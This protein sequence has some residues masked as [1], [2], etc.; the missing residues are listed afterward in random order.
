M[1]EHLKRGKLAKLAGCNIETIRYYENIGLLPIIGRTESGHRLYSTNDQERLRFI[2]RSRE[3]GF[4]IDELRDML[5]LVDRNAYTCANILAATTKHIGVVEAKISDL[6]RIK[7]SLEGM[8]SKCS[9]DE[10][11]DCPVIDDLFG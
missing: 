9:G 1:P 2:L 11:P 8:V 3:L 6:Q 10:V 7:A 5:S 4:S